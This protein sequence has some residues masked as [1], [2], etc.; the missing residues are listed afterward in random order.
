[1]DSSE[2]LLSA[3]NY[4]AAYFRTYIHILNRDF[5]QNIWKW[6]R[7][8]QRCPTGVKSTCSHRSFAGQS[9]EAFLLQDETRSDKRAGA[10]SQGETDVEVQTIHLHLKAKN[11]VKRFTKARIS[12]FLLHET[13]KEKSSND[14][15]CVTSHDRVTGGNSVVRRLRKLR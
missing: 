7:L 8:C 10:H 14:T 11:S 12:V 13:I 15:S 2:I 3:A 9:Q 1:M 6:R 5:L 4:L